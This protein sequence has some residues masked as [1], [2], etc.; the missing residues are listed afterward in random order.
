MFNIDKALKQ[1]KEQLKHDGLAPIENTPRRPIHFK[2]KE[3]KRTRSIAL[4]C[5][6]IDELENYHI[7][8]NDE[9]EALTNIASEAQALKLKQ[10]QAARHTNGKLTP[11]ELSERN[12]KV[13]IARWNKVKES[14]LIKEVK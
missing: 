13:A 9:F 12:R 8:D 4:A 14:K 5:E 6:I 2:I 1:Y 10:K 3:F 7:L 11:Q